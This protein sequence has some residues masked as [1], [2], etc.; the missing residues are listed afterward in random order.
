[1]AGRFGDNDVGEAAPLGC[2]FGS[3]ISNPAP[4]GRKPPPREFPPGFHG[5]NPGP[6][7]PEPAAPKRH[8][9]KRNAK[10]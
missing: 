8:P 6:S 3:V 5:A 2:G 4:A 1:M 9:R 10:Q 7:H